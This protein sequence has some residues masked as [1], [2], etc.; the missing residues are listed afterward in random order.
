M[1]TAVKLPVNIHHGRQVSICVTIFYQVDVYL[2]T[3]VIS[4]ASKF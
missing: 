2:R 1:M 3:C 4:S